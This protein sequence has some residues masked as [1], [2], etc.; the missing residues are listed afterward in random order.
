MAQSKHAPAFDAE[1]LGFIV[2]TGMRANRQ[3]SACCVVWCDSAM[4]VECKRLKVRGGLFAMRA[5]VEVSAG[6]CG[7]GRA[8]GMPHVLALAGYAVVGELIVWVKHV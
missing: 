3:G 4:C 8:H 2:I 1:G 6:R 7:T 5:A